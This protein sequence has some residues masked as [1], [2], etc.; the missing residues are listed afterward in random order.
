MADET[1]TRCSKRTEDWNRLAWKDIQKN[2]LR[3]QRRIYQ[4]ANQDDTKRVHDLQRLLLRSW[5][6][7]CLAVR[8]VTQD[9]EANAHRGLMG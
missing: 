6:A 1:N 9:T 2:V 7:R 8:Q 4:A 3:L 5:S